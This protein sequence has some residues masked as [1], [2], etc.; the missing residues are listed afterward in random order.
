[1]IYD[2]IIIGAGQAGLSIGYYLKKSK[3]NFMIIDNQH[4]VG[5]VW[6]HRRGSAL[7]LGVSDDA[8]Y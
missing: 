7:L 5:D 8:I 4:R 6:R 1:M 3:L 2:V